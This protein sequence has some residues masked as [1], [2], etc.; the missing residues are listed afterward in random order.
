MNTRELVTFVA[1]AEHKNYIKAAKVMNYAPSTLS[2]Q[3]HT[4]ERE[5]DAQ[6]FTKVNNRIEL[7]E[8]G[9]KFLVYAKRML[10]DYQEGKAALSQKNKEINIRIAGGEP[11]IGYSMSDLF[12][13][14][15]KENPNVHMPIQMIC[16]SRVPSWLVNEEIDIGYIHEMGLYHQ[17]AYDAIPLYSEPVHLVVSSRHPLAGKV[18]VR[19]SDFENQNFAFTYEDCCFTLEFRNRMKEYGVEPK[20]ELFLGSFSAVLNCVQQGTYIAMVPYTSLQKLKGADI[21]PLEVDDE[22]IR[23]WVQVVCDKHEIRKPEVQK[24]ICS[25]RQYAQKL[26]DES[27]GMVYR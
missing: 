21:V 14:I 27:G 1:L 13:R 9:Q 11:I 12:F 23:P 18:K 20:S 4:L 17:D 5:L 10:K 22:P 25:T 15:T 24:L 2:K 8:D 3:I 26:I 19:M 7:T 16:C 6:L